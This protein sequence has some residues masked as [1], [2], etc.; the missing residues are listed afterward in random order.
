M[1]S[2]PVNDRYSND[3]SS[4]SEHD[5]NHPKEVPAVDDSVAITHAEKTPAYEEEEL[6]AVMGPGESAAPLEFDV[7]L[8]HAKDRRKNPLDPPPP[9]FS[10]APGH[11]SHERFRTIVIY[12]LREYMYKGFPGCFPDVLEGRSIEPEDWKRFIEDIC[13]TQSRFS[14]RDKTL[15]YASVAGMARD[16]GMSFRLMKRAAGR[17]SVLKSQALT[18]QWNDKFFHPRGVHVALQTPQDIR[19]KHALDD[20]EDTPIPKKDPNFIKSVKFS[21]NI[22]EKCRL[23]IFDTLPA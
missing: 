9:S 7:K 5:E 3:D 19:D 13:Y 8:K 20:Q 21:D 22:E 1:N 10:R 4:D 11:L 2:V 17:R 16:G 15:I 12:S 14:T 23:L 18:D 6:R